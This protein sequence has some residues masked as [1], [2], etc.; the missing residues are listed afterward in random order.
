MGDYHKTAPMETFIAAHTDRHPTELAYLCGAR[1]VTSTETEEGRRWA[2]SRIK[3]I[4]GGDPIAA[5]FM[6][7]DIFEFDPQFKLLIAGNHKP[8]LR[9][10]DEAIRRRLHLI[11]FTVTIPEDERDET[12]PDRLKAEWGGILAWMIDGAVEWGLQSLMPPEAV[13]NATT[14]Y[15]DAEDALARW[16]EECC[17]EDQSCTS[18]TASLFESWKSWCDRTGEYAGSMK[19]FSQNLE[20]RGYDRWKDPRSRRKGFRGIQAIRDTS[21][22]GAQQ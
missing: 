7:Q 13:R 18:T 4:T 19:R 21:N 10:V 6:R 17:A 12:L 20:A 15:L 5:R 9:S 3:A 2:E 22:N 8:G 1:L 11:P 14:E 16:I